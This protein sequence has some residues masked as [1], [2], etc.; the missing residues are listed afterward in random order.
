M[1]MIGR[2]A[3][4]SL[5]RESNGGDQNAP[6]RL[7][8]IMHR[9]V[10]PIVCQPCGAWTISCYRPCEIEMILVFDRCIYL[11]YGDGQGATRSTL[12]SAQPRI[13]SALSVRANH[14]V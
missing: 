10:G 1:G 2:V 14:A 9:I 11:R 5:V 13:G 7:H 12:A 3:R 4:G 8:Q 6:F